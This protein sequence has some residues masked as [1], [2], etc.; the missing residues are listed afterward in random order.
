[1]APTQHHLPSYLVPSAL[2][3]PL[4]SCSTCSITS[5][6]IFWSPASFQLHFGSQH[7]QLIVPS[8][9]HHFPSYPAPL[10]SFVPLQSHSTCPITSWS[11]F[12]SPAPFQPCPRLQH[13]LL[14]VPSIWHHP[15]HL[16]WSP[17]MAVFLPNLST[18]S[19][20][21][22]AGMTHGGSYPISVAVGMGILQVQV[23]VHFS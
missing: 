16:W 2:F 6:S 15:W 13:V 14:I 20:E 7:V 19:N 9:W 5:W 21:I 12:R 22:P 4:Q 1:M 11:P 17:G 3:A 23:W 18:S 10:T 8:I